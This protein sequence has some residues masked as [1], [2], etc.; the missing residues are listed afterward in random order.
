MFSLSLLA[1]AFVP[2][3]EAPP[4]SGIVPLGSHMRLDK[5]NGLVIIEAEVALKAGMLEMLLCP[6][7]SKEHESILTADVKPR[8]VHFALLLAGAS[9]GRPVQFDPPKPPSGQRIKVWL[10]REENGR[11]TLID[12][13]EWI[14]REG[15]NQAMTA[16][17]VFVGSAFIRSPGT[18]RTFYVG[19]EGYLI[20]VANFPGAVIDVALRSTASDAETKMFVP[21]TERIPERETKVR[22]VL[23]PVV[24]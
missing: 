12:A 13:R 18:D 5:P 2:P 22:L 16:D 11:T 21:F 15:S 14:Q 10:E 24:D 20:C 4:S 7:K 23:E 6:R 1:L 19:D 3:K 17:F 8:D 9:P